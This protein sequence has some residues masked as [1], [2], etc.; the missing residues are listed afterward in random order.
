MKQLTLILILCFLFSSM[1]LF[2]Q[3]KISFKI[4]VHKSN[5]NST[6]TKDEISNLFLK[7]TTR[8]KGLNL[9]VEPVDLVEASDVRSAFSDEIHGKNV[10]AVKAYWQKMIFS[11]RSVPAPEKKTETEVL[12]F[13]QENAGA[14]GYV[15]ASANLADYDVKVIQVK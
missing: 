12:K 7:K 3:N 6:L 4:I 2:A 13:V 15:S 10:G 8:W 9:P 5:S 14:I 11:G 1:L